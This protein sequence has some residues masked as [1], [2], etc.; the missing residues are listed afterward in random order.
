MYCHLPKHIGCQ[1]K[2]YIQ[3]VTNALFSSSEASSG[4]IDT[5]DV[6]EDVENGSI[7]ESMNE[8]RKKREWKQK[9]SHEQ[10]KTSKKP[11]YPSVRPCG[12]IR[13]EQV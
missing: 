10:L 1:Q 11:D 7:K 9:P 2:H 4:V 12:E 3:S 13:G 8:E 5:H 6:T